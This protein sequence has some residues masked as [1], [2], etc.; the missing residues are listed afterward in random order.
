MKVN[1]IYGSIGPVFDTVK[2]QV[3]YRRRSSM[4]VYQTF[5]SDF[6]ASTGG[7][8]LL[9]LGFLT[10]LGIG[11]LI[12][13][14]PR[15]ATQRFAEIDFG[16]DE[17]LVCSSF[18]SH[19]LPLACVKAASYAKGAASYSALARH[20][21]AL[22][23]NSWAGSYSDIHGRKG[24]LPCTNWQVRLTPKNLSYL[25]MLCALNWMSAGR[26]I[27]VQIMCILLVTLSP[28]CF[29][30]IQ[31]CD[32]VH[33]IWYY[34]LES[35]AGVISIFSIALTQLSDIMPPKHRAASYGLY[36]GSFMS[37][38]AIAPYLATLMSHVQITLFCSAVRILALFITIFF[39]PETLSVESRL[40]A[41]SAAQAERD[42]HR[43]QDSNATWSIIS[44]LL[45][46]FY[47]MSILRRSSSLLLV[48]FGAFTSKM[49]F[50][51]D[52][53][54]FFYYIESNL[55]AMDK[56]VAGMMFTAGVCGVFVQAGLFK[57]LITLLGE[58]RLLIV[59]FGCGCLHNLIY[60]LARTKGFL[61][62]AL[63]VSAFT[64]LDI[65]LLSSV[66]SRTVAPTEQGQVQGALF[67]LGA[68][69][70]AIGPISFNFV[71]KHSQAFGPGTM[72][73]VGAIIY[74]FGMCAVAMVP[75]K[76]AT[77]T[78]TEHDESENESGSEDLDGR[79]GER[80][81]LIL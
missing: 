46:P 24:K 7:W 30:L 21:M 61:Y 77:E 50:S 5:L 41:A 70:E 40:A 47:K 8:L 2:A 42:N 51:A 14:V 69:A 65:A 81:V 55:G 33:P 66:A 45:Q 63:C 15:V 54:L 38:I 57:Y 58:R 20:L 79:V 27:G 31:V 48:A 72:F 29:W 78:S 52:A 39:L 28:I 64:H 71:S 3:L 59:S 6:H 62:V 19:E 23:M 35:F 1:L 60:G 75:S 68:L 13:V 11:G 10:A 22:L 12:G 32:R 25:Y 74:A 73:V 9:L 44:T 16:L 76:R 17:G 4:E 49:V 43:K 56:D 37:G 26:P 67:G 34:V 53:T 18:A 80:E 36:F